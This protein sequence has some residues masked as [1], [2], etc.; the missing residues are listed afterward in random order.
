M[1]T[2]IGIVVI[3]LF[4]PYVHAAPPPG[5]PDVSNSI[6]S[7]WNSSEG[8][9]DDYE[10]SLDSTPG[11]E[12]F[13]TS[14]DVI[15]EDA[16]TVEMTVRLALYE[17]SRADLN[18][19]D[20]PLG[21]DSTPMDGIPADYIRNYQGLSR[22]GSTVSDLMLNKV[23][24]TIEQ[25][26]DANFPHA[27]ASTITTIPEIDFP[28]SDSSTT[29][30]YD[31]GLDSIDEVISMDNDPFNPP[32]CFETTL[33]LQVDASRMGMK[34]GTSDLNRMMEGLLIM[35]AELNSKFTVSALPGHAIDLS[36]F[37]PPYAMADSV[38]LPGEIRS[39]D[40]EGELQTFSFMSLDN[41]A[42]PASNGPL[43][44]D[45][46]T[47]LSH[48]E[49][50]V[51]TVE[52]SPDD[53]GMDIKISI[54]AR[55]PS[56]TIIELSL[57][58]HHLDEDTLSNWGVEFYEGDVGLPW[59]TSDGIRMLDEEFEQDLEPVLD[60][61]PISE[62]SD[63]F[64]QALGIDINFGTPIFANPTEDGGLMF[65]H[66]P[67]ETCSE[68]LEVRYCIEGAT[69][70]SGEWPILV[71]SSTPP[72]TAP[73]SSI[74]D[75]MIRNLDGGISTL[76]LSKSTDTD[77]ANLLRLMEI[78][79]S[80][81]ASWLR[82]AVPSELSNSN[83]SVEII[84]P[85]WIDS[86]N[87]D[88][89]SIILEVP[90][91]GADQ[92]FEI[93]L[94]SSNPFDWG[95][96]I[97]RVSDPCEEDSPDLICTPTQK[98]CISFLVEVDVSKVAIHELRSSVS[99]DFS[100]TIS[101]EI[102]R[103]GLDP[104]IDGL[105]L[106]PIPSDA[107]R[108]I[109]VMGDRMNGGLLV[110]SGIDSTIDLGLGDPIEFEVSNNGLKKLSETLT[111]N[112]SEMIE[113]FGEI[114]FD[115]EDLG[116]EGYSL[117]ADISTVPFQAD[118]GAV[119]IRDDPV[120]RD[121][122]PVRLATRIDDAELTMSLRK[123]MINVNIRS[124][125]VALAPSMIMASAL[126]IPV[127]TDSGLDFDDLGIQQRVTPLME[128]TAF[129]TIRTSAQIEVFLPESITITSFYSEKGLGELSEDNGRQLLT[130]SLPTCLTAVTWDEC[131]SSRNSDI[132]T[133]SITLSWIFVIG[134]LAPYL[135]FIIV[136]LSLV[137]S[138]S[139]RKR[140]EKKTA[141]HRI[142]KD[143]ESIKIE[144]IMNTEFGK[145]PENIS[146][147]DES[148]FDQEEIDNTDSEWGS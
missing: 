89:N 40:L 14:V 81:D 147:V 95:N 35:G 139:R 60:G 111:E 62:I 102:Y 138:R 142:S 146:L 73:L 64:S 69:A 82:A 119:T 130:Y 42:S 124:T 19:E 50:D 68:S 22:G 79:A 145:L 136:S 66:T 47:I 67:G 17:M 5:Q 12:W 70:M 45:L 71:H 80:M 49:G 55:N 3:L 74:L 51:Q 108:R 53:V 110:D 13:R 126:G 27:N 100:A 96:A 116:L 122:E 28:S 32:I 127:F 44:M 92:D 132:V 56:E 101:L 37:P 38:D 75:K 93:G 99:V 41:L 118:F 117:S 112:Y 85:E 24:E 72:T 78:E 58:I 6:C 121:I 113:D 84:L 48:R 15:S 31:P 10:S 46:D 114:K 125:S 26:V 115:S 88:P 63:S 90:I 29:C 30:V 33:F 21:G 16:E 106:S 128:H 2:C 8:I 103:L 25:Y 39:R 61:I 54:D 131:S 18:L 77:L 11:P 65:R 4:A 144:Q 34:E 141:L 129:G 87:G 137:I 36:I 123:N 23:E 94:S 135:F 105:E 134:E 133:Y 86:M 148:Y 1:R 20:L 59:V 107:I 97:C 9:C 91:Y 104:E 57:G 7:S 120:M 83:L 76:D 98:T 140:R 109:L 143:R 52:I 43:T